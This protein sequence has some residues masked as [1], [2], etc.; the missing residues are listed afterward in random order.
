MK[1]LYITT[2]GGT[3]VFFEDFIKQLVSAGHTVDIA[4][5]EKDS[6]VPECYRKMGCRI[7]PLECTRSPLKKGTFVTIKQ[8]RQLLDKEK[9]DIVHCHTPIAAMCTRLAAGKARKR[10]TK[11]MYTAHGFHFCKSAPLVNWL[12]YF[13]IEWVCSFMTDVLLTMNNEDYTFAKKH[14][15]AKKIRY[16]PGVGID[17]DKFSGE[18]SDR[19][20]K[21]KEIGADENKVLL[22]SVGELSKNKNHEIIIKALKNIDNAEYIVAGRGDEEENLKK[23]ADELKMADRVHFLGYRNDI[24]ELYSVS[25][26]NVFPS[27]RE[28]L[29]VALMEAMASGLPVICSKIRGN[30]D[31][32]VNGKGG[33]LCNPSDESDF[34]ERI[35]LLIENRDLAR[36]MG[37]FNKE[38]IKTFS[39][40]NVLKVMNNIY[41]DVDV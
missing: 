12:V 11:V 40:E 26:I 18:L 39:I 21:R 15:H 23:L 36:Q 30:V 33:Y 3:M 4:T 7:F 2:I 6:K 32:V 1:I 20:Q 8:I 41:G 27:H 16:V 35:R 22:I 17:T 10:G 25:D 24:A 31:L 38:Y 13:P 37:E 29:P 19:T 9:Y 5:N 34:A 14:M 28:G